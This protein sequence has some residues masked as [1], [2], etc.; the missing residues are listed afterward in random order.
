MGCFSGANQLVTNQLTGYPEATT[1]HQI[2]ASEES[3]Y[4]CSNVFQESQAGNLDG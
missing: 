4:P 1:G 3:F 2:E